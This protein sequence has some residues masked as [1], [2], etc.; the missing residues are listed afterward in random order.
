MEW[1]KEYENTADTEL[2]TLIHRILE[3]IVEQI[4][5]KFFIYQFFNNSKFHWTNSVGLCVIYQ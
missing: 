2:S 1:P 3:N 5:L 4:Q